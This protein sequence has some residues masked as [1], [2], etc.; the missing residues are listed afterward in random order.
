MRTFV[1]LLCFVLILLL[2]GCAGVVMFLVPAD[3]LTDRDSYYNDTVRLKLPRNAEEVVFYRDTG[4]AILSDKDVVRR[5]LVD[6]VADQFLHI[7]RNRRW[8]INEYGE[9][10]T[11]FVKFNVLINGHHH[12]EFY[13]SSPYNRPQ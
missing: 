7:K 4:S 10:I 5:S 6:P 11:G 2:S 8:F 9:V 1:V 13:W 3:T 12:I